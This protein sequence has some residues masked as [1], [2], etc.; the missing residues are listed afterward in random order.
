MS[1]ERELRRRQLKQKR[2]KNRKSLS[3]EGKI[4]G[5]GFLLLLILLGTT[6]L[7]SFFRGEEESSF[8]DYNDPMQRIESIEELDDKTKEA[9]ELFLKIAK[10]EGLN[11]KITETY[12]SKERQEYLYAQGRTRPGK[13]VTWTLKSKHMERNA[14]D[15]AKDELG[16]EY[17]DLDFFRKAAE[18]GERI[19]LEAGYYWTDGQQDMPHFQMNFLSRVK[20]PDGYR[21]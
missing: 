21:K 19:G 2:R 11:V 6:S 4:M 20:Y 16:H 18:I 12:R 9:C 17:D 10:D 1:R 15:I 5:I 3:S 14:F 13:I 7:N 8:A